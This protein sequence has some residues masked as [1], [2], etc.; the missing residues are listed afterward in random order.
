MNN[1]G[2]GEHTYRRLTKVLLIT[3]A[4]VFSILI[5]GGF[6]IFKNEAPRPQKNG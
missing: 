4:A 3:L 6:L 2:Q 1:Q 5:A